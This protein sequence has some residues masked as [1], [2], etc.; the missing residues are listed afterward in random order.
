[1]MVCKSLP[2]EIQKEFIHKTFTTRLDDY[3]NIFTTHST[4]NSNKYGETLYIRTT[5]KI[6][7]RGENY[8]Q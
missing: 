7:S 1:M 6:N 8:S 3:Q 5:N 2:Q 4:I